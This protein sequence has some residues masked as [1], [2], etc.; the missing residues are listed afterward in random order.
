VTRAA[1]QA[2]MMRNPV[3]V[4]VPLALVLA[5]GMWSVAAVVIVTAMRALGLLP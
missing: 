2:F 1:V 4:A 3:L 5:V